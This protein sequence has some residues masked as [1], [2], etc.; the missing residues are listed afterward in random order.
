MVLARSLK[1]SFT[2][3]AVGGKY[4]RKYIAPCQQTGQ[5]GIR[6]IVRGSMGADKTKADLLPGTLDMLVLKIL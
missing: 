1:A 4:R 6:Y 3:M 5:R 2:A